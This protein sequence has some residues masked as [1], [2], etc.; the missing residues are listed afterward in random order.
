MK[1]SNEPVFWA[2]FGAGGV[3]SAVIGPVLIYITGI[4]APL[5]YLV[6][7]QTLSYAHL[8]AFTRN[9]IGK[10]A[11][12]TVI[13]LFLFHGVH[14]MFHSLHDIGVHPTVNLKRA[15]YGTAIGATVITAGLLL[16]IG[17]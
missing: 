16:G 6:S 9:P 10:L 5:G 1:R 3:L 17:F 12:L 14:R 2:L 15:F 11:V 8:L 7:K 4:G 13:S